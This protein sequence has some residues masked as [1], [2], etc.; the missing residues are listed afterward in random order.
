MG[1][2]NLTPAHHEESRFAGAVFDELQALLTSPGGAGSAVVRQMHRAP[3][4]VNS[5][6]AIS[7]EVESG[8]AQWTTEFA[9]AEWKELP[10]DGAPAQAR[11]LAEDIRRLLEAGPPAEATRRR[12]WF[13]RR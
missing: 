3:G 12:R 7:L 10:D 11:A 9:V 2:V 4:P 1:R 8:R 13:R 5:Q 6:F